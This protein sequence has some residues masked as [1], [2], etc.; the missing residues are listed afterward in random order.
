MLAAVQVFLGQI[1][2]LLVGTIAG[3]EAAGHFSVAARGAGLVVFGFLAVNVTLGPTISR[4]WAAH[5]MRRLHLALTRG[6]RGAFAFGLLASL[7]LWV[8]GPQFLSLFGPEFVDAQLILTLLVG[9]ALIDVSL[10]FGPVSLAMTGHQRAGFLAI[11]VTAAA[12]VTLGLL[13]IPIFGALG[14]AYGAL[15]SILIYNAITVS[16][17]RSRLRL[18]VTPL[19]IHPR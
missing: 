15:I 9:S 1:D 8:F 4:L 2:V 12:R 11:A 7:L 17:A 6:A 3:P 19:G 16:Y 13:L 14:A 10:G 5:D 18:D